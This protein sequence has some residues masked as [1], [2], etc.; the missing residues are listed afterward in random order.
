MPAESAT[1]N[2]AVKLG[3]LDL[4]IIYDF[5]ADHVQVAQGIIHATNTQ[6]VNT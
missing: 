3:I 4:D 2:N 1:A 5:I 6:S